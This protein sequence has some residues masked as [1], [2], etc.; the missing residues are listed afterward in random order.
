VDALRRGRLRLADSPAA[1][2]AGI[3]LACLLLTA[4][5]TYRG[6]PYERLAEALTTGA[7]RSFGVRVQTQEVGPKLSWLGTG[8][9]SPGR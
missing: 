7:A 4:F 6:F 9:S 1:R 5:F 8:A 3:A 2:I